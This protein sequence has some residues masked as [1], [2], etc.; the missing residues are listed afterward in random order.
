VGI[1]GRTLETG[2]FVFGTDVEAVILLQNHRPLTL[3]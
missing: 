1:D 3:Q 2:S